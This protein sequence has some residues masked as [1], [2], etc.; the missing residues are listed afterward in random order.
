MLLNNRL[1]KQIGTSDAW[2]HKGY[3]QHTLH[4]FARVKRLL[5]KYK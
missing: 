1:R 5:N 2:Y 4:I 3:D